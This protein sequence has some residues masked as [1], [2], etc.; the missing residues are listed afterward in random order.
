VKEKKKKSTEVL[1][2][3]FCRLYTQ[4]R[5]GVGPVEMMMLVGGVTKCGG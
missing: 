4:W 2:D 1:D 5:R 3:S